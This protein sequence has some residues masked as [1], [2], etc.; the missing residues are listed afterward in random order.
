MKL[1][2][3]QSSQPKYIEVLANDPIWPASDVHLHSIDETQYY[4][5]P[6]LFQLMQNKD[7]LSNRRRSVLDKIDNSKKR[8]P[9]RR[10]SIDKNIIETENMIHKMKKDL[11]SFRNSTN[12][13]RENSA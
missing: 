8:S 9:V 1:N 10:S 6:T 11:L 2:N 12:V 3:R 5:K 4:E 7:G 13:S